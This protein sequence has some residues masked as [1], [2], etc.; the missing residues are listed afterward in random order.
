MPFCPAASPAS[1]TACAGHAEKRKRAALEFHRL[2]KEDSAQSLNLRL[3]FL[4]LQHD[5]RHGACTLNNVA[6]NRCKKMTD[7]LETEL[8]HIPLLTEFFFLRKNRLPYCGRAQLEALRHSTVPSMIFP[9]PSLNLTTSSIFFCQAV[10]SGCYVRKELLRLTPD[11][12][13]RASRQP[14]PKTLSP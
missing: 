11:S 12:L 5:A 8:R 6:C 13:S 3:H 9:N 2:R 7:V 4:R 1:V 10:T 14:D